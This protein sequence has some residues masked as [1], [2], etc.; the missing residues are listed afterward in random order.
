MVKNG[1]VV[2]ANE[3][4]ISGANAVRLKTRN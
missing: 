3:A 2:A 1:R 4:D